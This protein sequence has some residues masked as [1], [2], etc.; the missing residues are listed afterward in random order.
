LYEQ[1][2]LYLL[3]ETM[4]NN[5]TDAINTFGRTNAIVSFSYERS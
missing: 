5:D 4:P 3:R 2:P 1:R